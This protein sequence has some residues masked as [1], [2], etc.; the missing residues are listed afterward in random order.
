MHLW[1]VALSI[2]GFRILGLF[3][4][5]HLVNVYTMLLNFS[6]TLG[7]AVELEQKDSQTKEHLAAPGL[8]LK[9]VSLWCLK[10]L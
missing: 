8:G 6:P 9:G 7:W 10:T 3:V 4:A 2:Q 1:E 5:G